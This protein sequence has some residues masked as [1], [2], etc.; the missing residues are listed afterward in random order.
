[1]ETLN[2][3]F[4]YEP[5]TSLK[6]SLIKKQKESN[7]F[8]FKKERERGSWLLSENANVFVFLKEGKETSTSD[9]PSKQAREV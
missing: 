4:C 6:Y 2:T 5:Q 8:N 1:M 9:F 3:V 7:K